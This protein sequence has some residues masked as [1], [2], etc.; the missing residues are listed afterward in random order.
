MAT[1]MKFRLVPAREEKVDENDDWY[2]LRDAKERRK[3]QNRINQRAARRRQRDNLAREL[4]SSTAVPSPPNAAGQCRRPNV[5][6]TQVYF[7]LSPD[8]KLLYV[9]CLNVSRAIITN[10]FIMSTIAPE[11]ASLCISRRIFTVESFSEAPRNLDGTRSFP[12]AFMPTKMQQEVPHPGWIDLLPSPQLRDNL[13]LAVTEFDVDEDEILED[14]IGD[15]FEAMGCGPEEDSN[16]SAPNDAESLTRPHVVTAQTKEALK[17]F[18]P[19]N[20]PEV[21]ILSWSDPWEISGWEVTEKFVTRWAFL[22]QGCPDVVESANKWR[23]L[24]GEDPLVVEI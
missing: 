19:T 6:S 3:R 16:D 7:P 17:T 12:P 2:G 18:T 21:G 24:R 14:L 13:I 20:T 4:E 23:A 8:H 11:T 10:Y 5:S 22:L 9:I 1:F 15:I